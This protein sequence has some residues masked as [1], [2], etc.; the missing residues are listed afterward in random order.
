MRRARDANDFMVV[1]LSFTPVPREGYRIGVPEPGLYVE[2]LNSDA[3]VY[4]GSNVGNHGAAH[5][6][7]LAAHGHAQ[8]LRLTMPPLGALFMKWQ[9]GS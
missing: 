6:E 5:T 3:D 7:P 4:G 8:S 9:R 2:M 1:V